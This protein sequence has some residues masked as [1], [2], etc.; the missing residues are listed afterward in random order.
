M[1][2]AQPSQYTTDVFKA[3]PY[4]QR[5]YRP[6]H[7]L[8]SFLNGNEQVALRMSVIAGVEHCL[9]YL[10]DIQLFRGSLISSPQ[11][12]IKDDAE[13]EQLRRKIEGWAGRVPQPG[14]FR[15]LTYLRLLRNHY[16]HANDILHSAFKSFIRANGTILNR[17]WAN[18]ITDVGEL[19]FKTAANSPLSFHLA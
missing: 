4:A 11:D 2:A 19:D 12:A 13:E 6:L 15:T 18:G 3:N 1:I 10:Q 17:F 7:D 5:I 16:A 8:P 9:A 14:H